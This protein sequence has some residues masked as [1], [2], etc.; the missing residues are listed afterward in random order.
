MFGSAPA[1]CRRPTGGSASV[2]VGGAWCPDVFW[3]VTWLWAGC[4]D[5]LLSWPDLRWHCMCVLRCPEVR[6]RWS[7]YG[8]LKGLEPVCRRMCTFR[9]PLVENAVLHMWHVNNFWPAHMQ[10]QT[11]I[12]LQ[13]YSH[14]DPSW[15]VHYFSF[16]MS[17]HNSNAYLK[18]NQSISSRQ[19]GCWRGCCT[20]KCMWI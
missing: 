1:L 8:H 11:N 14:T 7:Q 5:F 17:P 9:L 19:T 12:H 3:A 20:T 4:L 18:L 10:Q 2:A 15:S 13:H 16:Y 6:N